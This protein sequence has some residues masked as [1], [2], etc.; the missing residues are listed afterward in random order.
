VLAPFLIHEKAVPT[1]VSGE[2]AP[3]LRT[4]TTI[5]QASTVNILA[6]DACGQHQ[7]RPLHGVLAV[8]GASGCWAAADESLLVPSRLSPPG[9]R[10]TMAADRCHAFPRVRRQV[11]HTVLTSVANNAAFNKTVAPYLLLD[12]DLRIRAANEAYLSATGRHRDELLDAYIFDAFPDNPDNPDA[13]GVANLNASLERVLHRSDRDYM[14]VQRYDVP[15]PAPGDAFEVKYWSPVNS[16]I[17]DE[18]TGRAVGVLHHVEDVTPLWAPTH[19][20]AMPEVG[21]ADRQPASLWGAVARALADNERAHAQVVEENQQLRHALTS[22]VVIEQ[23]K[24]VIIARRGCT[25]EEAFEELRGF[26]RRNQ[27]D[28]HDVASAV[29]AQARRSPAGQG[30]GGL[31]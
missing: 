22:R 8:A 14:W 29:I 15:G 7:A 18:N 21:G 9:G 10:L 5:G 28:I 3:T 30:P 12:P 27:R 17:R 24:G 20:H 11:M 16:P 19:G 25:P 6:G 31:S 13:D 1:G 4:D 26:A 2:L 23:A